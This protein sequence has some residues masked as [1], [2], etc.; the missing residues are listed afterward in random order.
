MEKRFNVKPNSTEDVKG[1]HPLKNLLERTR[2]LSDAIVEQE[3]KYEEEQIQEEE[4]VEMYRK[5]KSNFNPFVFSML[6]LGG[7]L[8]LRK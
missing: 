7:Y 5:K 8:A 2:S 4:V 1:N 3:V 6:A